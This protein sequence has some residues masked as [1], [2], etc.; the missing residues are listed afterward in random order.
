MS[1]MTFAPKMKGEMALVPLDESIET[2]TSFP[3]P[4]DD[5][6]EIVAMAFFVGSAWLAATT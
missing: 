6:T 2:V 3:P 4:L 1:G 5:V